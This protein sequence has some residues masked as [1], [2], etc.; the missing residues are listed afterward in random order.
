MHMRDMSKP[1]TQEE[2]EEEGG[3]GILWDTTNS[4]G[5]AI[6]TEVNSMLEVGGA[7]ASTTWCLSTALSMV[8]SLLMPKKIDTQKVHTHHVPGPKC[9][10][11]VEGRARQR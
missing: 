9:V 7:L 11:D 2:E 1:Y 4:N 6:D 3:G 8:W 5:A 10:G